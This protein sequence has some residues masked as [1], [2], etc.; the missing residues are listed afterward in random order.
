MAS[1]SKKEFEYYEVLIDGNL[2]MS[3][4]ARLAKE[5]WKLYMMYEG[6]KVVGK[7]AVHGKIAVFEREK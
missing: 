6:V 4:I 2:E 5:G 3:G 1:S 7:E